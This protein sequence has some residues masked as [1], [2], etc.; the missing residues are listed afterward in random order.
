MFAKLDVYSAI[1]PKY[2]WKAVSCFWPIANTD[3]LQE[4]K[5]I[6]LDFVITT[7]MRF[8]TWG[9]YS[10]Q[11]K[12]LKDG[13]T[14]DD[15]NPKSAV[16][17]ILIKSIAMGG[18]KEITRTDDATGEEIEMTRYD[19]TFNEGLFKVTRA[20]S[21]KK[22][23]GYTDWKVVG[24]EFITSDPDEILHIIFDDDTLV[25]D[26]IMTV[27]DMWDAFLDSDLY[28]NPETRHEI[29]RCFEGQMAQHKGRYGYPSWIKFD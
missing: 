16:R 4:G 9:M 7:N 6:Q 1:A 22:K 15:V 26:D 14:N 19:Y 5:Y 25:A 17:Q 12:E 10:D 11:E 8:I 20:K 2:G 13:E 23:G 28:A 29:G 3:G 21:P 24:K 27:R 18:H